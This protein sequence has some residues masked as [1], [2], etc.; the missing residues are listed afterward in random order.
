MI[1]WI[2][3]TISIFVVTLLIQQWNKKW[4]RYPPGPFGLPLIGHLIQLGPTPH[5][6]LMNWKQKYGKVVAVN[7]GS[8]P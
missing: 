1:D 2:L 5:K 3:F 7:F 4:A 6:T 8:F